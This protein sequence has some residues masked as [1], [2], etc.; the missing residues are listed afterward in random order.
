[1]SDCVERRPA[2]D[3]RLRAA[4]RPLP[5]KRQPGR[6][7]TGRCRAASLLALTVAAVAKLSAQDSTLVRWRH[8]ADSLAREWRQANAIAD[9]VD[10]LER[11]RA[12]SGKDTIAVGAL[13]I[14]ANP[15]PLPLGEAAARAWPVI[16]SLYGSEAQR[17]TRR[18]YIVHA[19]DPDTAVPRPV[20][21]VGMEVPWNTSVSSLTLLLL[22]NAPMPD[23]DPAL[24]EWLNGPLRPSLRATQDRGATYVQL[25]TAPSQAARDCF[26]GALSR[27]RD[28]LEVNASTD[29]IT[30]WYPSAAERRALVVGDFADYFNHGANAAAFRSCAEGS[31]STCATL[32]R[33]LH[34]SVLPRPLGYDARA[35]LAHLAL[36]LGGREAYHRLLA[37]TA[38]AVGARLA[39][40]AGLSEDTLVARWRAEIIAARPASVA[41][42]SWGFVIALGW[43][44][45]FAGCGLRS[46]R[47]RVA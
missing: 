41:I 19:Y 11:E 31:D 13:R 14:V 24:R 2:P 23:P 7:F 20:L 36:R 35:T 33:T 44:V 40:A 32:L 47:W 18:P 45:V 17:L 8:S 27:C 1:M 6:Q 43:I 3:A 10:S 38:A 21:H 34:S 30:A 29:V 39:F 4:A 25:V 28:A 12:T 37:D 16:D 15:T 26:L 46:S 5:L 42:P 9:L 22:S